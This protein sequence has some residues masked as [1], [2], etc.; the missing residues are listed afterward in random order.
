MVWQHTPDVL[1]HRANST[2]C[3]SRVTGAS[4]NSALTF[5]R[6]RVTG[7]AGLHA[8][9]Q[10]NGSFRLTRLPIAHSLRHERLVSGHRLA[11][12]DKP[13]LNGHALPLRPVRSPEAWQYPQMPRL[14]CWASAWFLRLFDRNGRAEWKQP[15]PAVAWDVNLSQDGRYAVAALGDGT[16]R[17]YAMGDGREVLALFVHPDG[18]RW[19]AW[20]PEGFFDAAPGGDALIG[21]HL[22]QGPDREGSFIRV[23][24]VFNLFYRSDLVSGRL[25][26]GSAEAVRTGARSHRRCCHRPRPRATARACVGLARRKSVA[27]RFRIPGSR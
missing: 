18:R 9:I 3:G 12:N 26:P 17:W 4:W 19:V 8:L 16:I 22:N 5:S 27:G 1:D 21:Y 7:F 10:P 6:R 20:T 2:N 15:M 13:A 25:K 14:F 24:Q 23:D 11:N